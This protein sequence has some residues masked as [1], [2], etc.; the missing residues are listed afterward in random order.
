MCRT[1]EMPTLPLAFASGRNKKTTIKKM[2]EPIRENLLRFCEV[3]S[4]TYLSLLLPWRWIEKTHSPKKGE[5][6]TFLL[7]IRECAA[8]DARRPTT[9]HFMFL[10]QHSS[11][12]PF[13]FF[14]YFSVK[15]VGTL[16]PLDNNLTAIFAIIVPSSGLRNAIISQ[17][18]KQE[19]SRIAHFQQ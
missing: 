19:S 11:V 16:H 8:A 15:Y 12:S 4:T 10:S 5:K 9:R 14:L 3:L 18:L 17:C 13:P 2:K 7:A 6:N 1:P